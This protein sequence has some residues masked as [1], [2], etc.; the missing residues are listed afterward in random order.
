MYDGFHILRYEDPRTIGKIRPL[1][2]M[3][4]VMTSGIIVLESNT[5]EQKKSFALKIILYF[6][7]VRD[8]FE[9][10][11]ILFLFFCSCQ[12]IF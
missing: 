8:F 2:Q 5:G 1:S 9:V 4:N 7:C 11:V 10:W 12:N 3:E 6:V